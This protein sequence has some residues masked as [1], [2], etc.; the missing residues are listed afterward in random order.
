MNDLQSLSAAQLNRA[1]NL[2]EKIE[3]LESELASLLGSDSPAAAKRGPG[4][5]KKPSIASTV[6]V[7]KRKR[8]RMSA[9]GRAK[10]AAA[11]RAR[12]AK[13][14]KSGKNSL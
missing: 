6:G 3:A 10:I 1:A 5:P 14:K 8:R 11:A 9:A 12:W 4:R 7:S 2:K 13:A